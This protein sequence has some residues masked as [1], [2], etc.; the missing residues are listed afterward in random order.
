[1]TCAIADAGRVRH[2]G[3]HSRSDFF[4]VVCDSVFY[5]LPIFAYLVAGSAALYHF[6]RFEVYLYGCHNFA[7]YAG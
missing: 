3:G 1:M 4:S 2:L 5:A 6:E 7:V